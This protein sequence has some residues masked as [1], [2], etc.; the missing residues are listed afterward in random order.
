MKAPGLKTNIM[1]MDITSMKSLSTLEATIEAT[2]ADM[3]M[4]TGRRTKPSTKVAGKMI[5]TMVKVS[6]KAVSSITMAAG[7][8]V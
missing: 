1:E 2:G 8:S 5:D 4:L 7:N 3:A 6:F